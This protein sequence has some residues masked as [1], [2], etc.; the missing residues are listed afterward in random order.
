MIPAV[1]RYGPNRLC[2][3][4]HLQK[5]CCQIWKYGLNKLGVEQLINF[6]SSFA[7]NSFWIAWTRLPTKSISIFV[8]NMYDWPRSRSHGTYL[9]LQ[10]NFPY[11]LPNQRQVAN[12]PVNNYNY[13]SKWNCPLLSV[14]QF[15]RQITSI[16]Q[17]LFQIFNVT[18]KH[19]ASLILC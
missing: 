4:T 6:S 11:F 8:T 12:L 14:T 16:L 13:C 18:T 2:V 17:S 7:L 19:K 1:C 10:S 15:K 3:G 5:K 9:D